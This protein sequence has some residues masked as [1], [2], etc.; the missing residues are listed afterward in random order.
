MARS[1]SPAARARAGGAGGRRTRIGVLRPVALETEKKR[2]SREK[3]VPLPEARRN[4]APRGI[5]A[6]LAPV[7]RPVFR[8][9]APAAAQLLSDWRQIAGAELYARTSPLKFA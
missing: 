4:Y 6:L 3:D 9:R 1:K 7:V 2:V 8:K 5:A